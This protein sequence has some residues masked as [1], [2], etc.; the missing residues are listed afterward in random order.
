[1]PPAPR[2]GRECPKEIFAHY[3][4]GNSLVEFGVFLGVFGVVLGASMDRTTVMLT[5]QIRKRVC[6]GL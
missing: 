3:M 2:R 1:M 6:L 5:V 4:C